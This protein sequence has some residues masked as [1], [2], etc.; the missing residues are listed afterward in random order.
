MKKV[1]AVLL[2]FMATI[3]LAPK[4]NAQC[5][6]CTA[7]AEMGVKN[8]N[9]QTKGLNSGVLYLLAAPFLL[10]GVVG[11]IWYTSYRKKPD[12]A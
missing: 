10:A 4:A 12:V 1:L 3:A 2:F 7:N 5:A 11:T 9:T 6:M 8:G